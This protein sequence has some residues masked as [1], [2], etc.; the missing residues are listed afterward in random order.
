[1]VQAEIGMPSYRVQNFQL[2]QNYEQWSLNLHLLEEKRD[3]AQLR[4]AA[5]KQ[6]G[7]DNLIQR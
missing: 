7:V 1:M 6:R 5:Y 3:Q 4:V 2:Q